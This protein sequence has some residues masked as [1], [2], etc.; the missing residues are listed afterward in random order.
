MTGLF[1]L[2]SLQND[3]I[4]FVCLSLGDQEKGIVNNHPERTEQ[5]VLP[6]HGHEKIIFF[7]GVCNTLV[8]IYFLNLVSRAILTWF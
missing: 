7:L 4:C 3:E 5:Y 2:P 1:P 8:K 6:F